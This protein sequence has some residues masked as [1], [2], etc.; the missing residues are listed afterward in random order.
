MDSENMAC[1]H[2]IPPNDLLNGLYDFVLGPNLKSVFQV[3]LN[4]L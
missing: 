2:F 4:N 1:I 3:V